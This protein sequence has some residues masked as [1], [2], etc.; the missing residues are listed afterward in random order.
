MSVFYQPDGSITSAATASPPTPAAVAD[1]RLAQVLTPYDKGWE[2]ALDAVAYPSHPGLA[3]APATQAEERGVVE[4][5]TERDLE[6]LDDMIDIARVFAGDHYD[7]LWNLR[8]R[9]IPFA[10]GH[11]HADC[12]HCG[13]VSCD[14]DC[15]EALSAQAEAPAPDGPEQGRECA[16]EAVSDAASA[17]ATRPATT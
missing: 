7:D 4:E 16:P 2:A 1:L 14:G 11:R 3:P 6:A 15:R 13:Q 8:N 17:T 10:P 5:I 9:I 12:E